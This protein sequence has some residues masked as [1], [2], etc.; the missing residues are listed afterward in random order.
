[1]RRVVVEVREAAPEDAQALVGLWAEQSEGQPA[2]LR[3]ATPEEARRSIARIATDPLESLLV[4]V[5][6][7]E[8]VGF[9]SLRRLPVSPLHEEDAVHV[10]HL[11]V[12]PRMRRRGVGRALLGHAAAW[13]DEAGS[14]HLLASVAASS[15]DSN[16]FLARLGLAQV[17][18]V[19]ALPVAV[20]RQRLAV[21][22]PESVDTPAL[23]ARR[24][25]LLRRQLSA[26]GA[27]PP[28]RPLTGHG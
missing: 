20:L 15:R 16:R 21:S 14:A 2:W 11:L 24:R 6:D 22:E 25:T 27:R 28:A 26:R 3:S 13:A 7:H 17:T 18:T 10:T 23:L 12:A 9:A 4:A 19:R 5:D 1:M 8:I